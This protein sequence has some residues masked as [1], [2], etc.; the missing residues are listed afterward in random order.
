MIKFLE[1]FCKDEDG[2][3]TVDWVIL[4]AGVV[5]LAVIAYVAIEENTLALA[6]SAA[7]EIAS[8]HQ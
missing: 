1:Y 3:V 6:N 7:S 4:T 8:E 2:A 5:G